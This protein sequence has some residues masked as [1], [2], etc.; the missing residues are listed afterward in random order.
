MD[1]WMDRNVLSKTGQPVRELHKLGITLKD[2]G[3]EMIVPNRKP[4]FVIR[5]ANAPWS[6]NSMKDVWF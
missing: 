1:G 4:P 6:H 2:G 3:M 5:V